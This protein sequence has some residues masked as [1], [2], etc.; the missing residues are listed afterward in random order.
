MFEIRRLQ[1]TIQRIRSE[2][3]QLYHYDIFRY[4]VSSATKM[5]NNNNPSESWGP[6]KKIQFNAKIN[7]SEEFDL[8]FEAIENA[9]DQEGIL[10]SLRF[11]IRQLETQESHSQAD[12]E[13]SST[14]SKRIHLIESIHQQL[15]SKIQE[16]RKL[17]A[18]A[19][20]TNK[21]HSSSWV[22]WAQ[23]E[24]RYTNSYGTH[25]FYDLFF[26]QLS[27]CFPSRISAQNFNCWYRKFSCVKKYS[28]IPFGFGSCILL[29]VQRLENWT[30][31]L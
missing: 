23:F 27:F 3:K 26:G 17:F 15:F 2:F 9:A 30:R 29:W 25:E 14:F 19:V 5:N 22:A 20:S 21:Y 7:S 11:L 4:S 10:G 24:E 8:F 31:L 1:Q 6:A 12:G 18:I 13:G 28:S 16:I